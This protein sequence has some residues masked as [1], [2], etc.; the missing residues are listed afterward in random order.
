ML[1]AVGVELAQIE[2]EKHKVGDVVAMARYNGA[3]YLP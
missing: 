3:A 2:E 1:A